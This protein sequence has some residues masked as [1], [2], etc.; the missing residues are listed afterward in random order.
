MYGRIRKTHDDTG[1]SENKE[2]IVFVYQYIKWIKKYNN[3]KYK[4]YV[5]RFKI[6]GVRMEKINNRFIHEY[7]CI[8]IY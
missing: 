2:N 7:I 1:I 6:H 3:K 8:R 4:I 5:K